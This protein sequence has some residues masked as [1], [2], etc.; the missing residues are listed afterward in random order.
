VAD[1]VDATA[2]AAVLL[3]EDGDAE[4]FLLEV[5]EG[6]ADFEAVASGNLALMA[7]S[8]SSFKAPTALPRA[9]LEG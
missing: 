7:V 4:G 6:L 1:L 9:T 2:V 5:V 8:T 3:V